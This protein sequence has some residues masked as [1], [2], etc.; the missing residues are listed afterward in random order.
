MNDDQRSKKMLAVINCIINHNARDEGWAKYPGINYEVI[1]IL[2]KY[3]VGVIQMPCPEMVCLGLL[4][5]RQACDSIRTALDTPEGRSRCEEL[6]C[7]VAETIEEFQRNGYAVVAILGGDVESPGCAVP[8]PASAIGDQMP[9]SGFG[10][11]TKALLEEQCK[12]GIQIPISGIRD[13]ARETLKEDL[14]WLDKIL[15]QS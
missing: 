9:G 7:S 4:R 12:R 10:V 1:D 11:F 8:A 14:K 6:S 3:G 5:K 15:A 13:S 2:K